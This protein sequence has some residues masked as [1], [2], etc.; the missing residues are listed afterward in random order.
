MMIIGAIA[1][2]AMGAAPTCLIIVFGE[3]TDSFVDNS[4]TSQLFNMINFTQF[5]TA[6]EIVRKNPDMLR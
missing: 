2:V 3:M 6:K 5:S 4:K 1:A